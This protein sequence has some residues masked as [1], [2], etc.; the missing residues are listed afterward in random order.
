MLYTMYSV[1][2]IAICLIILTGIA[3]ARPKLSPT[4]WYYELG[5]Q[6]TTLQ[7]EPRFSSE[8]MSATGLRLYERNGVIGK[9]LVTLVLGIV[10]ILGQT[11]ETK[12]GSVKTDDGRQADIYRKKTRKEREEDERR[13][14]SALGAVAAHEYQMDIQVFWPME[15]L[16]TRSTG[17]SLTLMPASWT[18]DDLITFEFGLSWTWIEDEIQ[19]GRLVGQRRIYH[20]LSTPLRLMLST[21]YV[22]A[23][24][25]WYPNYLAFT[26]DYTSYFDSPLAVSV[27]VNPG[28]DFAYLRGGLSMPTNSP[29]RLSWEMSIGFRLVIEREEQ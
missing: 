23:D 19:S 25:Q 26:S 12:V 5:P 28:T 24:A 6:Y 7:L 13:S 1:R 9:S 16:E 3:E 20:N 2:R 29:D 4:H 22:W 10:L 27:T 18:W 14:T 21:E 11:D 8:P 15:A 17:L